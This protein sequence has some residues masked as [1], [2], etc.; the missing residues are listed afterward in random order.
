MNHNHREDS[1]CTTHWPTAPHSHPSPASPAPSWLWPGELSLVTQFL[2]WPG[3]A[4]EEERTGGAWHRRLELFTHTL[5]RIYLLCL[6]LF[7][8]LIY[9]SIFISWSLLVLAQ[10]L[11]ISLY[12]LLRSIF[13]RVIVH[14][15]QDHQQQ[16]QQ[17]QQQEEQGLVAAPTRW[18]LVSLGIT[19]FHHPK[20]CWW[21]PPRREI[22][23][24]GGRSSEF[25]G[26]ASA[27]KISGHSS[28]GFSDRSRSR[29]HT[30][31]C[32]PTNHWAAGGE[33]NS[34]WVWWWESSI[35]WCPYRS[36]SSY[37]L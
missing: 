13:F 10:S 30:N 28:W 16:S 31:P 25:K 9:L 23:S 15:Y 24:R 5:T 26:V 6:Y 8:Y 34:T 21:F 33:T 22:P 20:N 17:Q 35:I 27:M 14:T 1:P 19:W 4:A 11:L 18:S 36:Q 3:G 32:C 12:N 2:A 7:M 29:G 37:F